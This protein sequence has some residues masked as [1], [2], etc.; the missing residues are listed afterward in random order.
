MTE[1]L[2]QDPA[3]VQMAAAMQEQM[4]AGGLGDLSL[5]E[6][7]G[8]G[9]MPDP[10]QYMDAFS[11]MMQNPMF[12][13]AAEELGKGLMEKSVDSESLSMM[14]LFQDP[15]NAD[16]LKAKMEE[17][18]DDSDLGPM[19]RDIEEN[20]QAAMMKYMNDPDLMTKMG[21]KFQEAM[22][23]ESFVSGLVKPEDAEEEEEGEEPGKETTIISATS[24]GSVDRLK[25]L[26]AEGADVN[27]AD[28]EGRTALH[29]S[30]GYSEIECMKALIE[31]KCDINAVDENANTALSYAAGYGN[32]D[33]VK[34]LLDNEADVS[35][36]NAEGKTAKDVAEM[37]DQDAIVKLLS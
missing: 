35:L 22:E 34:L 33:A 10:S 19:I 14:K 5:G 29:W 28:E 23:D 21:K 6:G 15:A 8:A 9:G 3:F 36:K 18:K 27:E 25:E 26:L 11:K 37:N 1:A 12:M 4:L 20:G 24:N 30:A 17:L 2:T 31:A 32:E 7:A 13:S 16:K